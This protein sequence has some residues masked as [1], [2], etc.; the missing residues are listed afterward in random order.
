MKRTTAAWVRKAEAD[1]L[2]AKRGRESPTP[3]HDGVFF[4]CQQCGE[5]YLKGLLEELGLSIPKIHDLEDL[6]AFVAPLIRRSADSGAAWH[7]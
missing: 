7:F 4:H 1:L 3:L 5:K 2:F 6:L